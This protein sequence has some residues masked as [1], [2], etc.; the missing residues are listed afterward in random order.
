M[1]DKLSNKSEDKSISSTTSHSGSALSVI[2]FNP[3]DEVIFAMLYS[4]HKED[5]FPQ[6][7]WIFNLVFNTLN[8]IGMTIRW[9]RWPVADV[10]YQP[11]MNFFS[12]IDFTFAWSS[13]TLLMVMAIVFCVITIVAFLGIIISTM[14]NKAEK[15]VP[16]QF[17]YLVN[18]L[19]MLMTYPFYQPGINAFIGNYQCYGIVEGNPLT[20]VK[21]SC[22]V[23]YRLIFTIICTIIMA[24]YLVAAGLI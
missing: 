5:R 3:L 21:I 1:A 19:G 24:L 18:L 7:F 12:W 8:Y 22:N 17:S 16:P 10:I 6:A 15:Q 20:A 13:D 23:S 9:Q 14:L 4:Y 11:I 2:R